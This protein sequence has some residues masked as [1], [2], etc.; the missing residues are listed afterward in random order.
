MV[1]ERDVDG[2]VHHK[3]PAPE[4]G[5]FRRLKTPD[6]ASGMG[7]YRVQ[8]AR[9]PTDPRWGNVPRV[10]SSAESIAVALIEDIYSPCGTGDGAWESA[11]RLI[12]PE[13]VDLVC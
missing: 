4:I 3:W 10:F 9:R 13:R 6:P 1:R 8:D 5:R 11:I 7:V 12:R 2:S